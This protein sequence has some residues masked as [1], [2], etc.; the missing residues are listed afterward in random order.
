MM[1]LLPLATLPSGARDSL[2]TY[3]FPPFTRTK[4]FPPPFLPFPPFPPFLPLSLF[5]A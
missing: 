1:T 4:T 3:L 2:T 5:F